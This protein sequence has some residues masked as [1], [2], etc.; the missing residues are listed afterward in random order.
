MKRKYENDLH[1]LAIM[2]QCGGVRLLHSYKAESF[3][4][5]R[6]TWVKFNLQITLGFL[7]VFVKATCKN[8]T[9][10]LILNEIKLSLTQHYLSLER[11]KFNYIFGKVLS[12]VECLSAFSFCYYFTT[13]LCCTHENFLFLLD[14]IFVSELKLSKE[15]AFILKL[16]LLLSFVRLLEIF[17][18]K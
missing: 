11:K 18:L 6:V 3:V 4:P 13:A 17:K 15:T 16:C 10:P 5:S 7:I 14:E 2:E 8:L 1:F 9:Q 12:A